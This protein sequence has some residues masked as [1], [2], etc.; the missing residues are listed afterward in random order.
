MKRV[1][2][3]EDDLEFCEA[4]AKTLASHYQALV[5][6]SG[7]EGLKIAMKEKPDLIL[8]DLQMPEMDGFEVC[9]QLRTKPATREIPIIILTGENAPNSRVKG[10]DSGA[11]DYVSKPFHPQELLARIRARL[12]RRQSEIEGR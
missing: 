6:H 10:L 9:E 7:A 2:I 4:V 12:R 8:I 11:D 3:I 5:A 1:L